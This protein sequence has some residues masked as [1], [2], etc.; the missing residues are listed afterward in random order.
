MEFKTTIAERIGWPNIDLNWENEWNDFRNDSEK[1][2]KC[3][4]CVVTIRSNAQ[5]LLLHCIEQNMIAFGAINFASHSL[6]SFVCF[7]QEHNDEWAHPFQAHLAESTDYAS[8]VCWKCWS[9]FII[10]IILD[11]CVFF[12]ILICR[13]L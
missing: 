8:R 13:A 12:R 5:L 2:E 11:V 7:T 1:I 10:I 6:I 9:D 3:F 4:W